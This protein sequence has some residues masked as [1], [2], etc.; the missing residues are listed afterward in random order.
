VSSIRP[1]ATI[2]LL[3]CVGV[4]LYLKIN[5]TEPRLPPELEGEWAA[6]AG[7]EAAPFADQAAAGFP[8]AGTA[9]PFAAAPPA[10]PPPSASPAAAPA[11][12]PPAWPS[13][14]PAP[15]PASPY[16]VPSVARAAADRSLE[17][18]SATVPDIPELPPLP[19][20][21]AAAAS[22]SASAA[23]S[24]TAG[25]PVRDASVAA[26]AAAA[27]AAAAEVGQEALSRPDG[28][29]A[30]DATSAAA[31]GEALADEALAGGPPA[32]DA[33]SV[34]A[35]LP[36]SAAAP[37]PQQ[38]AP[39]ASSAADSS[40]FAMTWL[41]VQ[42]A[43]DRGELSQALLKL[44]D[45]YRDPSLSAD[46]T[47]QVDDLLSQLAGSVIYEGPPAHRLE[48]PYLVQAGESLVEIGER[49]QV[50]WQLLAKIN[51]IADPTA[52][53]AGQELKVVRGP[54]SA[55]IDMS[56]RELTLMLERRY[57]G[58]FALDVPPQTAME[59]GQWKV[60]QK[61]ITPSAAPSYA[62]VGAVTEDRSL[63][64]ANT[65]APGNAPALLRGP[66]SSDPVAA[67]PRGRVLQL[68]ARDIEDVY[69][70]LSVG[71]RVMIRR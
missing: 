8:A 46:Q 22:T 3:A 11:G 55:V 39:A 15:P 40:L 27:T 57:A 36:P 6:P 47:R 7:M 65:T 14:S 62:P 58:R 28:Q 50:P 9:P 54:F 20:S 10:S 23:A 49:F 38:P 12:G 18:R 2:T 44:S 26:F 53:Q 25:A 5:E 1:L 34:E 13:A 30:P 4:V 33:A 69:D 32:F 16:E 66:G 56:R 37:S 17:A 19:S 63:V 41:E 29:P 61:L 42:A 31:S 21:S 51:G 45:W 68:N 64:L 60:D 43:L 48:S 67:P 71:S 59:E 35:G 70:I 52:L 24:P